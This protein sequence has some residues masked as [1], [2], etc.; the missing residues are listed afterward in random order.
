MNTEGTHRSLEMA[1]I[2]TVREPLIVLDGKLRAVVAS[3]SFYQ[4]F[5]VSREETEGCPFFELGNGQWD[6]PSLRELLMEI[7]PQHTTI[8]DY[9][10]LH[11]FPTI[12]FRAMLLNAR[13][14]FYEGNGSKNVLVAIEDVTKRRE[15]RSPR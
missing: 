5:H 15:A 1:I 13:A 7:L 10:V 8:E 9:E 12:G 2:D 6:I 11:D 3:R 4:T 14:V